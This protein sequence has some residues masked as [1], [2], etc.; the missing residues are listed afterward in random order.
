MSLGAVP[1][2]GRLLIDLLRIVVH[3]EGMSLGAMPIIDVLIN[4]LGMAGSA[5]CLSLGL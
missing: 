1:M 3:L 2:I 5:Q 4:P